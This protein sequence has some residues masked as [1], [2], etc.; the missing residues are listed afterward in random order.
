MR[1]RV[2]LAL[3]RLARPVF[4]HRCLDRR[5]PGPCE[6]GVARGRSAAPASGLR[7]H[8]AW[9]AAHGGAGSA[10]RRARTPRSGITLDNRNRVIKID[11]SRRRRRLW[12]RE[13]LQDG[14]RGVG[15]GIAG[16]PRIL[17][18]SGRRTPSILGG[19][20]CGCPPPASTVMRRLGRSAWARAC[21]GTMRRAGFSVTGIGRSRG[22]GTR[23]QRALMS[24]PGS[25]APRW[26]TC[27]VQYLTPFQAV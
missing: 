8:P 21:G 23:R 18:S 27:S 6:G 13:R 1:V 4:L 15:T 12:C 2:A 25:F 3:E 24:A 16:W 22:S 17:A 5:Q 14:A 7:R 11:P 20:A 10:S 9:P 19:D 26:R